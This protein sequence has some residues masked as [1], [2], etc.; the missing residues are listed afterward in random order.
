MDPYSYRELAIAH[1]RADRMDLAQAVIEQME[2]LPKVPD[3]AIPHTLLAR[4]MHR[5]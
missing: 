1:C 5:V 2:T 3:D 4:A